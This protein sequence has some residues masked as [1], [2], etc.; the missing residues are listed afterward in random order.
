MRTRYLNLMWLSLIVL[1]GCYA[2]PG[3]S[4]EQDS[5]S[6]NKTAF[7][8]SNENVPEFPF[9]DR[10]LAEQ[11]E[12]P[13]V[14]RISALQSDRTEETQYLGNIIKLLNQSKMIATVARQQ[15]RH[16]V[17]KAFDYNAFHLDIDTIIFALRR[18]LQADNYAPRSFK[19]IQTT[20]L[21]AKY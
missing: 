19:Q 15:D 3:M 18:Y 11:P 1:K 10:Q 7:Y 13:F 21:K 6:D 2:M 8:S 12:R 16:S 20:E 9:A 4:F 14:Q 5:L 17:R